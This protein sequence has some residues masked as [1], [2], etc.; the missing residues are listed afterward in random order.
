M[1]ITENFSSQ[2]QD[3]RSSPPFL[4][5]WSITGPPNHHWR[6]LQLRSDTSWPNLFLQND[7]FF[8][9]VREYVTKKLQYFKWP[10]HF[11]FLFKLQSSRLW[12]PSSIPPEDGG[13]IVLWN[14][15]ILPHQHT[16]LQ[17]RR[18]WPESSLPLKPQ[19]LDQLPIT[20]D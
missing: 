20:Q 4:T 17:S 16:V 6:Y 11:N 7:P 8:L 18:L 3:G 10:F 14:N 9:C 5:L 12:H 15:G 19:F 1:I 2:C 13:S